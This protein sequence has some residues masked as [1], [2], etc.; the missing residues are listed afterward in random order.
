[1]ALRN[2]QPHADRTLNRTA[3]SLSTPVREPLHCTEC[4]QPISVLYVPGGKVQNF[5]ECPL[6]KA[7]TEVALPGTLI[8]WWAGHDGPVGDAET[9]RLLPGAD[10]VGRIG[11]PTRRYPP[12]PRK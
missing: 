8:D 3:I 10:K 12:I 9:V 7:V 4:A 5:Y 6:C 11:R 1:M 2:D